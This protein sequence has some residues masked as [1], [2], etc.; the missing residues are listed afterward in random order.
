M[1]M[2]QATHGWTAELVRAL[3]D[4]GKRYECVDGELFVTPAPRMA[5]QRALREIFLRL[6]AYLRAHPVGE[7][8]WSPADIE[9]DPA[10]LVQPD[11]FV[12][13]ISVRQRPERWG[14]VR[15]LLLAVEVLSPSTARADR[16][17]KRRT[18][19]RAG[20]VEYWIVDLSARLVERWRPGDDRAEV[21][22]ETLR[23]APD[24]A[25]PPLEVAL[26]ELFAV[27]GEEAG[28]GT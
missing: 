20:V 18:Y 28:E 2:P 23:W 16:V 15:N 3:P 13:P 1:G 14:D 27:V 25:V 9:F 26:P 22:T 4:D 8:L 10:T 7:V 5:H 6:E 17:V 11:L 12:F 19:Q 21:L 24:L